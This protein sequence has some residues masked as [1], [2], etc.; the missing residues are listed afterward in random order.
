MTKWNINIETERKF[1]N[2]YLLNKFIPIQKCCQF[3]N[4][5]VINL[6]NKE[7]EIKPYY[8]KM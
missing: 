8:W 1:W 7:A 5:G 3:C 2:N 4:H 6:I